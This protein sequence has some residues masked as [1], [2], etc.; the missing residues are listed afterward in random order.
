MLDGVVSEMQELTRDFETF[1][2][3]RIGRCPPWASGAPGPTTHPVAGE[4]RELSRIV[5][6]HGLI[7]LRPALIMLVDRALENTFEVGVI[8]RVSSGK[9]S[10][11]NAMIGTPILPTGVLPVT[12]FP[13]RVR[14]GPSP[15]LHVAYANGRTDTLPVD[16]IHEFVTETSNPGNEKRLTRLL[17]VYPADRVPEDVTFVDTPG[18]GSVA[19]GGALQTFAYLPRCD[20][21][22]FLFE[23]TALVAEEDLTVLAFLHDAGI[24]T[25]VLLSKADLLSTADLDQ[26]RTYVAA[27]IRRRLGTDV[28]VRPVSTLPT[29]ASLLRDWLQGEVTSL[30]ARARLHA[31]EA[32]V[33][34]TGVLRAQVIA[35]LERR[36]TARRSVPEIDGSALVAARLREVS[37]GLERYSR[38]LL[39]LQDRRADLV[40]TA[41]TA[42]I[43]VYADAAG[44]PPPSNDTIRAA[45]I[46]PAE[47]GGR[48]VAKSSRRAHA[49]CRPSSRT[50]RTP[51]ALRRQ[52]SNR[53]DSIARHR[54]WTCRPSAST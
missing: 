30:G 43:G 26:V 1:P 38:E 22:T 3:G 14:R 44:G 10:L 28:P 7:D 34:K 16:R 41:L 11:L 37:A 19:S 51:P 54:C 53:S 21:A 50:R 47:S 15:F 24:T 36:T 12:A 4:L 25:S 35:T 46:R 20:H 5:A 18:L 49:R 9:S 31:Q 39:S 29:H 52:S 42:A 2:H 23:A 8:G 13:T 33:R 27:Q 45:L 6:E 17:V 48:T 32:L 40:E